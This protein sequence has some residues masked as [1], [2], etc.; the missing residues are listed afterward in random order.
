MKR[1]KAIWELMRLEHGVMLALAIFIG[2]FISLQSSG[3]LSFETF[4]FEKFVL[5]FFVALFLEAST[6][7]LNDYFDL[8]IDKAN[9]RAD[10][11]LARGDITP[12]AAIYIFLLFFPLGIIFSY[13]VNMTC[14]IIALITAIFAIF[15][16]VFLKKIKLLS[17]FYI[18]YVMAIPFVFGSAAVQPNMAIIQTLDPAV[19]IIALIAFLAGSG[20]EIMKDVMD[21]SGDQKQ[22]VKSFP[23]YIGLHWSKRIAS[24]FYII[25]VGLSLIPFIQPTYEVYYQNYIYLLFVLITDI[26]LLYTSGQLL[27]NKDIDLAKYRKITLLAI[28]LGLVSFFLGAFIG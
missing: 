23:K 9:K 5:T 4:P 20:R 19:I 14:F 18:A 15:Y 26:I 17:N 7:A 6:F 28:F 25:A 27:F 8:D 24:V 10:R 11:P 13:F 22:G 12:K 16:D 1:I 21:F 2:S 3:G